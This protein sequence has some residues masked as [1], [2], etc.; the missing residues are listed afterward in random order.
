[1]AKGRNFMFGGK[2]TQV[3]EC[4][5]P[6][7]PPPPPLL[8]DGALRLR[9]GPPDAVAGRLEVLHEVASRMTST[10]KL[11]TVP[12]PHPGINISVPH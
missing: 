10:A 7:P 12:L 1:M 2:A 11:G 3:P 8:D 4:R 6:A 9:G 5:A